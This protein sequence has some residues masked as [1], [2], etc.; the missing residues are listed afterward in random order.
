MYT[1]DLAVAISGA[2]FAANSRAPSCVIAKNSSLMLSASTQN[3][4]MA[5]VVFP[6]M[7]F[8]R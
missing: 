5:Y 1:R 4:W 3:T 6:S 2:W 8:Q 7:D